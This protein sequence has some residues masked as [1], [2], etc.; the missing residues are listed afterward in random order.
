MSSELCTE[1]AV[2]SKLLKATESD[3]SLSTKFKEFKLSANGPDLPPDLLSD[4]Q[5]RVVQ[6][7]TRYLSSKYINYIKMY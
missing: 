1:K 6:P 7:T 2:F 4:V 3:Y 5:A